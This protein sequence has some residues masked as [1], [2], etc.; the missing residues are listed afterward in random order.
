MTGRQFVVAG[1]GIVAAT[2]AVG[3]GLGWTMGWA[4]F[5]AY[6]MVWS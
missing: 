3:A 1:V 4:L 2:L 6:P 5:V